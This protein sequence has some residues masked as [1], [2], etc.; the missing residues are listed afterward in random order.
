MIRWLAVTLARTLLE[1]AV[2]LLA[3]AAILLVLSYRVGRRVVTTSPDR[4]ETL[5]GRALQLAA[6]I[7]RRTA[8]ASIPDLED[9]DYEHRRRGA[10]PTEGTES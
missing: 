9:W 6:L 3:V 2:I 4:L 7:P 5:S 10:S 8:P 1:S